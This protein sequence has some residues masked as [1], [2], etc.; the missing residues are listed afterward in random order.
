MDCI[1]PCFWL[2]QCWVRYLQLAGINESFFYI[3]KCQ[4]DKTKR[5]RI[6]HLEFY[7]NIQKD[8]LVSLI[9]KMSEEKKIGYLLMLSVGLC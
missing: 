2:S 8:V 3:Y 5:K 6:Y 4:F 7:L 9:F 1:F